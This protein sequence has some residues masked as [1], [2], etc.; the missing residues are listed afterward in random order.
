MFYLIAYMAEFLYDGKNINEELI[1]TKSNQNFIYFFH[2]FNLS[3]K[4]TEKQDTIYT[5]TT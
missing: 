1:H 2:L 5:I 4:L 3:L